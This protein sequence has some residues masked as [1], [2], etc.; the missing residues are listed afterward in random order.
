MEI[1]HSIER[2]DGTYQFQG[3]LTGP[4]LQFIVEYGINGLMASGAF[5]FVHEETL[6]RTMSP[7]PD[8]VTEQ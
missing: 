5:P 8:K 3:E 4:E 1:K 7:V 6:E 2:P